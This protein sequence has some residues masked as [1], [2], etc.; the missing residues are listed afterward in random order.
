MVVYDI[1]RVKLKKSPSANNAGTNNN[2]YI[3]SAVP[4]KLESFTV[5]IFPLLPIAPM[6]FGYSLFSKRAFSRRPLFS[7]SNF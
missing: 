7:Y 6:C 3:I 5:K 2:L 1:G 4:P